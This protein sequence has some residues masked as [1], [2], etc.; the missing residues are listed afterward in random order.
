MKIRNI[1]SAFCSLALVAGALLVIPA[2]ASAQ[3]ACDENQQERVAVNVPNTNP[4]QVVEINRKHIFCGEVGNNRAKGFHSRP[5]GQNPV[6]VNTDDADVVQ[7]RVLVNGVEVPSG[8][9]NLRDFEITD[10]G[11]TAVKA[12]STM[13]PDHCSYND[14]L[15]AIAY[16]SN[17][18]NRLSGGTCLTDQGEEFPIQIYWLNGYI[19]T[20]FPI[21]Q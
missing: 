18:Q 1:Y 21:V 7:H 14:V 19:N 12:I 2:S 15:T 3:V 11:V 4:Q 6:T 13:Y 16:A 10:H 17:N 9:Y 8:L 20:A 5:G